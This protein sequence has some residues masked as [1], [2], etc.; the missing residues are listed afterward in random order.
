LPQANISRKN[1][2]YKYI[3]SVVSKRKFT[4]NPRVAEKVSSETHNNKVS[5]HKHIA[6]QH[7]WS[8]V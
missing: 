2:G 5:Y 7:L 1:E 8:T 4:I 3:P 6:R